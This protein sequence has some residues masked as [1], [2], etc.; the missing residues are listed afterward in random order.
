MLTSVHFQPWEVAPG[1]IR[2]IA[3]GDLQANA[4]RIDQ[5]ILDTADEVRDLIGEPAEINNYATGGTRRFCGIRTTACPQYSP[6]SR[7]SITADRSCDAVD[8]HFPSIDRARAEAIAAAVKTGKS[9]QEAQADGLEA[10]IAA[11]SLI[12]GKIR[13]AVKAGFL[14]HLGGMEIGIPWV[15]CDVRA[16]R[17]DGSLVEFSA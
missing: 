11:A 16:R 15:H 13:A 9:V 1:L 4:L 2:A 5:R 8:L 14:P 12:R 10:A 7:H 17:A 3:W 6:T